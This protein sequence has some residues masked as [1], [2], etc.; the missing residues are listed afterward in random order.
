MTGD[1]TD[2]RTW[3]LEWMSGEQRI[4][5][6]ADQFLTLLNLP[7]CDFDANSEHRL[8]YWEVFEAQLHMLM[9][10]TL[11]GD[12]C[13]EVN[14]K[15]LAYENKVLVYILCNSLTPMNRPE[16]INGIVGNALLAMSQGVRF[17]IPDLFV[18]IL[19]CAADSPQDL[20]PY[21]P[22][23]MYAIEQLTGEHFFCP[24]VL[25]IFMPPVRNTLKIVKYIGKGKMP[26]D[27]TTSCLSACLCQSPESQ[28]SKS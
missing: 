27:A 3:I 26:V 22:W 16:T 28:E 21:A 19:A 11:F 10:P 24:Y 6:S 14:Q 9:D 25:K 23:I 4:K 5:C 1:L 2:S 13:V 20:K 18:R 15:K 12:E 7:R 17:D 8:H